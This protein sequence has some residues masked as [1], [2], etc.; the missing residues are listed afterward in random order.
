MGVC[1]HNTVGCN[2]TPITRWQVMICIG[3]GGP[4]PAT[5]RVRKKR[6]H[7]QTRARRYAFLLYV[8]PAMMHNVG[9]R[10]WISHPSASLAW[11]CFPTNPLSGCA[12]F[13]LVSRSSPGLQSDDD[14]L[15]APRLASLPAG[16][17]SSGQT[18]VEGN[19]TAR[20]MW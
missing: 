19:E 4:T 14:G 20:G 6:V 15:P 17:S 12:R 13:V 8:E 1:L 2:E 3:F 10:V 9:A 7:H 11:F 16:N 18:P 5:N